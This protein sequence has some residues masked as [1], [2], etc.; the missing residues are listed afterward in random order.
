V[1]ALDGNLARFFVAPWSIT[2]TPATGI[3]ALNW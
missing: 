2:K 3:I 1:R